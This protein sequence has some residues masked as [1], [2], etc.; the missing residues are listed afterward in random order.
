MVD[1]YEQMQNNDNINF[2]KGF[3]MAEKNYGH[4]KI[5]VYHDLMLLSNMIGN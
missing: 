1:G 4:E 2:E 5:I 3:I